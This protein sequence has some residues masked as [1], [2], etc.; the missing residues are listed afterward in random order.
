MLINVFKSVLL[1][2]FMGGILSLFWLALRPVTRRLFSPKWQYYIWLTVLLVMVLPVSF[3][4]PQ[5]APPLAPARQSAQ[6]A[7]TSQAAE[8]KAQ[9]A[10][11]DIQNLPPQ[12]PPLSTIHLPQS[13]MACGSLLWLFGM[14]FMI[15]LQLTRYGLFLK[16]IRGNAGD[17][18]PFPGIP[19]RLKVRKTQLLDAPLI[20]GLVKPVLYL[21]AAELSENDLNYIF[22]HELTHY[23]RH[24]LYYKWAALIIKSV[25]WFNPFIYLVSKQIDLDC[26]VSCDFAVISNLTEQEQNSYM[27]MI[28]NMLSMTRKSPRS[29]TTQMASSKKT[30]KR[31]FEMIRNKKTTSK[32][33]SAMSAIL[34]VVMLSTTVF[35]SGV[36]SD[37][38]TDDYRIE[39]TNKGEKIE[40]FN[41]PFIENGEVYVPLRELFEKVGVM[42]HPESKIEW[43]NGKIELTVAYYDNSAEVIDDHKSLNNGQGVDSVTFIFH[44][45]IEIGKAHILDNYENLVLGKDSPNATA[46]DSAPILRGS[47]AYIPYSYV[48]RI[49]DTQPWNIGYIVRDKDRNIIDITGD[50]FHI[51]AIII[52]ENEKVIFKSDDLKNPENTIKGFFSAFADSNFTLMKNYCTQNCID[53]FFGNDHVF[54]IRRASLQSISKDS[55]DLRKRGFIVGE[56]AA[57][58]NAAMTPVEN[59]AY[60]LNQ[61]TASFY[62]ILKQHNGIYLIDKFATGL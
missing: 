11:G 5:E 25:H 29:L 60:E 47:N 53:N 50:A 2:S 48:R 15:C 35:A 33:V 31:R 10:A 45:G 27:K 57:L 34:A 38:T 41:K 24:D 21:P 61:T 17:E 1:M 40:L 19:K 52:D 54:G 30:L 46:M 22:M 26:E 14:L 13:L 9:A 42:E 37:L 4:L 36:L 8:V 59:S 32:F 62:M 12:S 6:T 49:L 58:V 39:I 20:I 7:E 18:L 51:G 3:H 56:W 23:R 16:T 44:L 28:L 55:D 43:D